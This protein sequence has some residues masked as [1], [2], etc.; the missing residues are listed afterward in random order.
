MEKLTC[1]PQQLNRIVIEAINS[2]WNGSVLP[3]SNFL[4]I[5]LNKCLIEGYIYP[6][7]YDDG[8]YKFG[9]T[10]NLHLNKFIWKE[11]NN[12]TICINLFPGRI[13]NNMHEFELVKI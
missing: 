5:L 2:N 3:I 13:F 1:N 12:G 8:R 4:N 7:D 9:S 11:I 10:E 6:Q